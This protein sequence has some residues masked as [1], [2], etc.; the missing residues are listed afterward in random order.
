M[1]LRR[2]AR[3]FRER[4]A[5]RGDGM[6]RGGAGGCMCMESGQCMFTLRTELDGMG[7]MSF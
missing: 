7:R 1:E 4:A 6:G 5:A 3:I 2:R